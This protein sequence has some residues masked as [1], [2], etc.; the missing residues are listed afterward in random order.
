MNK[1]L[2]IRIVMRDAITALGLRQLIIE[3]FAIDAVW[4]RPVS[5][6]SDDS[7]TTT[8]DLII[9]DAEAFA[10][11]PGYFI[12]RLT[13]TALITNSDKTNNAL[14]FTINRFCDGETLVAQLRKI[15]STC[16]SNQD[17]NG[18][19]STREIDVLCLLAKGLTNKEIADRLFI[20][21]NTVLTH[22]KNI[23]SKLGIRS[24][25]GLT[26]YALM[27]G[28]ITPGDIKPSN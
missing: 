19:L 18:E 14:A 21:T 6:L 16:L 28:Y 17:S 3:L 5:L 22:R 1:P 12:P 27:N 8:E 26:V 9:A 2:T 23:T 11:A 13:R 25:S 20:S 4:S 24:V 15:I 7:S 10:E